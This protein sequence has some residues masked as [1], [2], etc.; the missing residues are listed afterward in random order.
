MNEV[1]P[2][3]DRKKIN[4]IKKILLADSPRDHLLFVMGSTQVS[5]CPICCS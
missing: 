5:E 2:I 1:Q 3:R 4:A